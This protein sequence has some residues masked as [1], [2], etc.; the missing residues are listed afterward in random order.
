MEFNNTDN[1]DATSESED[2]ETSSETSS[3]SESN[4]GLSEQ[5]EHA[6]GDHRRMRDASRHYANELPL[7]NSDD[8][9]ST[10][11]AE[12]SKASVDEESKA[13]ADESKSS[14]SDTPAPAKPEAPPAANRFRSKAARD[15]DEEYGDELEPALENYFD[16]EAYYDDEM[17]DDDYYDEEMADEIPANSSSSSSSSDEDDIPEAT[18]DMEINV[19][20]SE[21]KN[22]ILEIPVIHEEPEEV[23]LPLK[24][25]NDMETSDLGF[26]EDQPALEENG[27]QIG[28]LGEFDI[29]KSTSEVVEPINDDRSVDFSEGGLISEF[30]EISHVAEVP[31]TDLSYMNLSQSSA[32]NELSRE[33][34][35]YSS[36]YYPS[37]EEDEW[38]RFVE[39]E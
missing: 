18:G 5:Q 17:Y 3:S 25:D 19:Q 14:D 4:F 22:D 23:K 34:T 26:S 8:Q 21:K 35:Y 33:E 7:A 29:E 10:K 37:V 6:P 36:E 31:A 38:E 20:I 11:S 39:H 12:E 9:A 15:E 27:Y 30:S 2:E 16:G 28:E 24:V 1:S 13:S 32:A